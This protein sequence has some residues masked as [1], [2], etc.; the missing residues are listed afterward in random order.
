[1]RDVLKSKKI[2]ITRPAMLADTLCTLIEAKGGQAIHL[3]TIE[4]QPPADRN[5]VKHLL[6][7][8]SRYHIGIFVSQIAVHW[9]LDLLGGEVNRLHDLTLVAVGNTTAERLKLAGINKVVHAKGR[10]DSESL[11]M[12]SELQASA[13]CGRN[14]II[15]RGMGGRELLADTLRKRGARVDYAEVYQRVMPEYDNAVFESIWNVDKPDIVVIT[16]TEGLQNLFDMLS[17][18]HRGM[19]LDT[20]LVVIGKRIS[21]LAKRLGFSKKPVVTDVA[22]DK[23]IL[24]AIV[25]VAGV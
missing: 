7:D 3:P 18:E 24:K 5:H 13:V 15:F 25:Q 1:M 12:I 20:Q 22:S 14:I 2:L 4:I 8:L 21:V 10:A 11:L 17:S 19:L 9:T 6:S 23:G 16:S